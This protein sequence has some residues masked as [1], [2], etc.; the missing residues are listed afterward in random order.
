MVG[1]ASLWLPILLSAVIVWVASAIVHMVLPWHKNDFAPL[2][3]E[4]AV[5]DALRSTGAGAGDYLF[6]NSRGDGQ[7]L[8]SDEFKAKSRKGPVGVLTVFPEG[9]PF[10][11]G[12]QLTQWFLY[13]ALVSV[14]AGYIASRALE[15]GVHYLEVF[16]FAGATAFCGYSLALLQRSI[17]WRQRW[18][19]TL[20]SVIDGLFYALLTAGT[21]GWLWPAG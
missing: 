10:A 7:Y 18:S 13:C 20:K 6:P 17:W 9:D 14:F 1:L 16:R 3:D 2:P 15:P 12:A 21:F 11:M 8:R 19:V 5:M 4:D